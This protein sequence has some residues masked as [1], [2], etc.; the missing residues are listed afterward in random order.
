VRICL[1]NEQAERLQGDW[2]YR[3]ARF[4]PTGDDRVLMTFGQDIREAVFELLRWLGPGAELIE[5]R[6]WR[7]AFREELEKMIV[8]YER[9]DT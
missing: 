7:A 4:E 1:T 9:R 5:P 2:Y 6:E 3:H 8:T